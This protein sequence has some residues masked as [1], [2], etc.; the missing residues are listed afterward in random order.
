MLCYVEDLDQE[1]NFNNKIINNNTI[2]EIYCVF[3]SVFK[4]S[5]HCLH[6]LENSKNYNL[7]I[8][9]FLCIY[10]QSGFAC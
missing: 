7:M 4:L 8:Y 5:A 6:I 1:Q 3:V 9:V 10:I 2:G